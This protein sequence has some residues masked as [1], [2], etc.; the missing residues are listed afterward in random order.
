MADYGHGE[1][2]YGVG[3]GGTIPYGIIMRRGFGIVI[4]IV[5]VHDVAWWMVVGF[6]P[7]W[8]DL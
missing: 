6:P 2:G 1:V 4:V 7:F 8:K 3:C 5:D